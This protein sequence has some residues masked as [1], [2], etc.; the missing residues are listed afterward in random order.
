[1]NQHSQEYDIAVVGLGPVGCFG[2]LLFAEAGLRVVAFERD[3]TVYALPRAVNLD[4][5]IIRAFQ[6]VGRGQVVQDL[7]QKVRPGDRAGFANSKREWLFGQDFIEFGLNGWQP[8]NMFDQ[9][10]FEGYLREEVIAHPGITTHIGVEVESVDNESEGARISFT[11]DDSVSHA[12]TARYAVA[13]DGA[14]SPVRKSLG[15]G[16]RDLGYDHNWLVVDVTVK[17][18]HTLANDTLQVCDPDRIVTYVCTKDPYRRWEF[19]MNPGETKEQMLDEE[20]I[21]SLIDPWTPRDTYE[22]R[23]AAVYQFHAAT[24]ETW[25]VDNILLAGDAAHQTPPFL[26]QGMNA[27]MRDVIN[28][29]WKFPLVLSGQ[30]GEAL[31][32]SYAAERNAHAHDLVEWAVSIGRLMEHLAETERCE[33]A[34]LEPP[35]PSSYQSSGYGQGREQ[36]PIREG[37]V[38]LEQVSNEGATGYLLPQPVVSTPEGEEIRLDELM[39]DGF[40]VLARSAA[41]LEMSEDS[42]AALQRLGAV[43]LSL[44]G[45]KAVRGKIDILP[46][47]AS[48]AI[49]RPDRLVFGHTTADVSLD[50]LVAA[51]ASG[52]PLNE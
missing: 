17:A 15:I 47:G 30:V 35:A 24:A 3:R 25:R 31:L 36:P 2:A 21:R 9:P 6:K 41:D 8:S 39:G 28:L 4:G 1:M 14:A 34:G 43:E 22:I 18:G 45:L 12:A 51:L 27:G 20:M 13:A 19:K 37:V 38:L 32:D 42:K 33:R 23:R 10:E 7:M 49:I 26:G 44:D 40:T 48:A 52:L 50:D 46:P 5:E 29:A 16:W 11:G